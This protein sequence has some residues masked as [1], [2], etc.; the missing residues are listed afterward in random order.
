M[1]TIWCAE[2]ECVFN[3]EN[4]CMA[5]EINLSVG[6]VHTRHQGYAHKWE[7]RTFQMSEEVKAFYEEASAIFWEWMEG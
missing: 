2:T 7:C 4:Q 5:E 6:Y 3:K 1:Q